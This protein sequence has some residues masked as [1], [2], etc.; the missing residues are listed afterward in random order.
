MARAADVAEDLLVPGKVVRLRERLWR[1]DYRDGHVFSATALDGR[2]N[3]PV[4]FHSRLE[5][6]QP[7]ALP[8]PD[9]GTVGDASEQRLLL[10]AYRFSLLHGTA[11]ILGLQR[12]RAIPTD[13][14]IVPL[15]MALNT[16][17][18][19]LLVADDVGTGKTVEAGLILSELLARGRARR[20]LLCVPAN[21]REQWRDTLDTM[22]HI[23]AT[24]VAGHLLPALERKLL[25]G[26]SVWA[27][28]D[29]VIASIDYLKT[30]TEEVLAH[31]W[32][33]LV[34]DEA[35]LAAAP[36]AFAGRSSSDMERHA[37]V[38]TAADRCRHLLLLTATPHNGYSDSYQSLF[39]MLDPTLV[40]DTALGRRLD[41]TRARESH[42]VQRRRADIEAW[43]GQR[44]TK[45]PFPARNSDEVIVSLRRSADLRALID[46]LTGYTGEL[47]GASTT[48][49]GKWVAAHL[50]KRLLSS[51]AAFR[52]S[53]DNR[54][55]AIRRQA[56]LDLGDQAT[57]AAADATTDQVFTEDDELDAV[58]L[59]ARVDLPQDAELA[60]LN[61]IKDLAA[62]VTAAKDPKLA[63]LLRLLPERMNAHPRA[64]RVLVFT[65]FKDTLDYLEKNLTRAVGKSKGLPDGTRV[66]TI[67]GDMNLAQ[68][69][70]TFAEFE[71]TEQAVLVATDCIS[72]GV[73]LQRAC[74]ELIHYELPWNPNRIEQRNGRIDRFQQRE[75]FV[76]IRTLV[77]DDA[78]DASLLYLIVQKS[79]QI[80]ADYGFVPPFLANSDILLYLS[81]PGTAF[82]AK[83]RAAGHLQPTLFDE[84]V[85]LESDPELARLTDESV[86]GTDV[87]E[88][89]KEESFYGQTGISLTAIEDALNESRRVTGTTDQVEK[90]TL[91]ALRHRHATVTT[92]GHVHTVES[93]PSTVD[94]VAPAGH[95][96]TFDTGLGVDDPTLDVVD[97]AHPL[98][99]RLIDLTLD[100]ARLP[101][102]RGRVAAHNA[103]LDTGRAAVLHVLFR[104]VANADPPVLLEE[105]VPLAQRTSDP[106][107]TLDAATVLSAAPGRGAPYVGDVRD[108]AADTLS[109]PGLDARLTQVAGER[110]SMLA[111]RHGRLTAAWADGL[112]DVQP[113]SHD[114]VAI[115]L[116]YPEVTR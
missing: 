37:F 38:R 116:V 52:V 97:L 59:T 72:E 95:R 3:T 43:Y 83:L 21:L 51:P 69:N 115:T 73:N 46:E 67:Y 74:A 8:F 88:R 45:S 30:R 107:Q 79:E 15:L 5:D 27:A 54:L 2:D 16:E 50:H 49:I 114:L 103:V 58:H 96:F 25:P 104:Y 14:Q 84:T 102:C 108:D 57:R 53:I 35:H 78:L 68:R 64:R 92:D 60:R 19:R 6:V 109:D 106:G 93:A 36:H 100:E 63:E 18:V 13:F 42:V 65:K 113:T 56:A 26:Q 39:E 110:A 98:L 12:S 17:R 89:V 29:V 32:D 77:L 99:R 75:P 24:V 4:R 40:T 61:T 28:H 86:A 111:E 87:L 44:G 11:P 112:A 10:D 33:A 101:E 80:R 23:D 34:V 76:G 22:F 41:R 31:Q 66:F 85:L 55:N 90:F 81:D 62:K 7:G 82:R 48:T 105:L 9:A 91:A 71:A 47:Y 20:V 1:V 70:A 94:D